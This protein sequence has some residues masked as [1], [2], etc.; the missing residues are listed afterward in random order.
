MTYSCSLNCL[1][2][3]ATTVYIHRTGGSPRLLQGLHTGLE[4]SHLIL[5]SRQLSHANATL[6]RFV[7]R[8]EAETEIASSACCVDGSGSVVMSI[9][10]G[11]I[12]LT[13]LP[14]KQR[15]FGRVDYG[16][17]DDSFHG[18]YPN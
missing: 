8:V 9:T 12:E 18:L 13:E 14:E 15:I 11:D 6:L 3:P 17:E 1:A 4:P 5:R 16:G 2:V 10:S 7:G